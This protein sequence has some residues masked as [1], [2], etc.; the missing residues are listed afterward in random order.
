MMS[1]RRFLSSIILKDS[2]LVYKIHHLNLHRQKT[3]DLQV[4]AQILHHINL[5]SLSFLVKLKLHL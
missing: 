4:K 3:P 5:Q 2:S 1:V